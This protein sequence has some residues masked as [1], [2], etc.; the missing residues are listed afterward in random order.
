MCLS[1][2]KLCGGGG[3]TKCCEASSRG[4]N[5]EFSRFGF[6]FLDNSLLPSNLKLLE[7]SYFAG[8]IRIRPSLV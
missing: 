3:G 2:I 8:D 7:R 1:L 6:C 4:D 5:Y